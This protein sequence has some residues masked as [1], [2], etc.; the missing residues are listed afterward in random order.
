MIVKID[1]K[2]NF[3][4]FELLPVEIHAI[5]A[6]ELQALFI[7]QGQ[8]PP[9]DAIVDWKNVRLV[10]KPV[11]DIFN[12]VQSYY[13]DN[14]YSFVMTGIDHVNESFKKIPGF[15]AFN[16]VPTMAE[17]VDW[18]MMEKLERELLGPDE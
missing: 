4:V 15:D 5:M 16:I 1:T 10:E 7:H 18:V 11:V 9:Y 8:I 14:H 2:E 6:D 17:A 3:K 12:A 13:Q